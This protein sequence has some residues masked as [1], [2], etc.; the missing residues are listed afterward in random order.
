MNLNLRE[1]YLRWFGNAPR[2]EM[3]TPVRKS[4]LTQVEKKKNDKQP[5]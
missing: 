1:S 4:G 2:R 3:N 5:K